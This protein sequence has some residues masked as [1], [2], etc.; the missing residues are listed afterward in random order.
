MSGCIMLCVSMTSGLASAIVSR[1][2]GDIESDLREQ[3]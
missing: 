1:N 2:L 3:D